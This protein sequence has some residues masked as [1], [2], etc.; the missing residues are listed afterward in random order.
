MFLR[1]T[2]AIFDSEG[3]ACSPS[4]ETALL[5]QITLMDNGVPLDEIRKL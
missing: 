5:Q 4:M 2:R 3:I 1:E